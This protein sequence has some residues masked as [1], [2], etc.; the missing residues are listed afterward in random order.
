MTPLNDI[1]SLLSPAVREQMIEDIAAN[2]GDEV[3]WWGKLKADGYLVDFVEAAAC[4]NEDRVL[5]YFPYMERGDVVL[6]NHP[7]GG[8]QPSDADMPIAGDLAMQGIGFYIVDNRL[9][10]ICVVAKPLRETEQQLLDLNELSALLGPEGPLAKKIHKKGIEY[11][12]RPTQQE[13]L[14]LVSNGFNESEIVVA[15]GGTGIGK[16]FAYLL[17]A[18]FWSVGNKQRVVVSTAT[19]NLQQQLIEKDIPLIQEISGL[20]DLKA[21]LVKGRNNYLCWWRLKQAEEEENN[22]LGLNS[23]GCNQQFS[24]E[25]SSISQWANL[26]KDG[27]ISDLGF[28]PQSGVWN[29][30]CGE[31][32][33]C[34]GL[35]CEFHECCFIILARRRAAAAHILIVN[36]HLLFADLELRGGHDFGYEKT[37][38]LPPYRHVILDEAHNIER[39]AQSFFS[40]SLSRFSAQRSLRRLYYKRHNRERGLWCQ[41]RPYAELEAKDGEN[42]PDIQACSEDLESALMALDIAAKEVLIAGQYNRQSQNLRIPQQWNLLPQTVQHALKQQLWPQLE[43]VGIALV[44]LLQSLRQIYELLEDILEAQ[45]QKILLEWKQLSRRFESMRDVV[46]HWLNWQHPP[47]LEADIEEAEE[48]E[49]VFWLERHNFKGELYH[50][51]ITTQINIGSL[52]QQ[53]LYQPMHSV[54]LVSA[55]LTVRGQFDHWASRVGLDLQ[56]LNSHNNTKLQIEHTV[57][58]W[59]TDNPI[60]KA[61]QGVRCATFASPFDYLNNVHLLLASDAPNPSISQDY[62]AYI[63]R[64]IQ[65]ATAVMGGR[66]L[67]LFTSYTAL[68][69]CYEFLLNA[70][71]SDILRQGDYDNT[72]LLQSFKE[73]E[74]LSLLA[75]DSFW[76]G[77]DAPGTTLMQVVLCRLPFRS[78]DDPIVAAHT[79]HLERR[80][81]NAFLNYSLPEAI[82]RFRQGFGRLMR[83]ASDQ[84]L[85]VVLDPRI[86]HKRYGN[87]FLESLPSTNIVRGDFAYLQQY[88]QDYAAAQNF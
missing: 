23:E 76:E 84:G 55:T 17:P 18:A 25:L 66:S 29:Q 20:D 62:N 56:H 75:T 8:V 54:I 51:L 15:E 43:N 86:V 70:G 58:D 78:P 38:V 24:T 42:L 39:S 64:F 36:H 80:G 53:V 5:A 31:S 71:H 30:V 87:N 40:T 73:H 47:Q 9:S 3:L 2:S 26:T 68:N 35:R 44:V 81:E 32:D 7:S 74:K 16:S 72:R 12:Q 48:V 4:G 45:D 49:R 27:S 21:E 59:D 34:L 46:S 11:E 65:Q 67:L 60:K 10:C 37:A 28:R 82:L 41:L 61:P 69:K 79:E 50:L 57:P 88:I 13:L 77:V 83:R 19:I 52:L 33:N 14:R 85:V 22:Y 63:A 1:E 6:H